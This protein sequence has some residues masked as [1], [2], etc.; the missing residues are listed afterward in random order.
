[1]RKKSRQK[2]EERWERNRRERRR[3]RFSIVEIPKNM[4]DDGMAAFHRGKRPKRLRGAYF[5]QE[6]VRLTL[7]WGD[8]RLAEC[9]RALFELGIVNKQGNF[10]KKR[11]PLVYLKNKPLDDA[12]VATRVQRLKK[13]NPELSDREACHRIAAAYGW[14]ATRTTG[15]ETAFEDVRNALKRARKSGG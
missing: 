14:G 13:Y 2:L 11:G 15:F 10:T 4:V 7:E 6:L 8:P 5:L 12:E 3:T 1:M 9:A